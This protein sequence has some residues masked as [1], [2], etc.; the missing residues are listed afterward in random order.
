MNDFDVINKHL[1]ISNRLIKQVEVLE[2]IYKNN[3]NDRSFIE[4]NLEISIN[5]DNKQ[6]NEEVC[7]ST[8]CLYFVNQKR[9][10]NEIVSELQPEK[11]IIL[12]RRMINTPPIGSNFEK[13]VDNRRIW[14]DELSWYLTIRKNDK[15]KS[16]EINDREYSDIVES[17]NHYKDYFDL[18]LNLKGVVDLSSGVIS[19]DT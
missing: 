8:N 6:D 14:I 12:F 5:I 7:K 13:M 10:I 16:K 19:N 9:L 1:E 18:S 11:V 4:K 17:F 15:N 2:N 3:S